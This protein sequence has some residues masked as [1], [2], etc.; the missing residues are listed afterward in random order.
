MDVQGKPRELAQG[1]DDRDADAQIGHEMAVHDV[2]MKG[3]DT[4]GLDGADLFTEAGEV[5]SQN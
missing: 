3:C 2:A 4:G 1:S 5:R